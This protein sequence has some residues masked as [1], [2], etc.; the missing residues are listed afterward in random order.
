MVFG[1]AEFDSG[2]REPGAIVLV[3]VLGDAVAEPEPDMFA[4]G[5]AEFDNGWRVPGAGPACAGAVP[6]V[7]LEAAAGGRAELDSGLR[8]VVPEVAPG[9]GPLRPAVV[10][11]GPSGAVRVVVPVV[12][13]PVVEVPIEEVDVPVIIRPSSR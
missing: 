10:P 6:M 7:P 4:P 1:V 5:W 2:W 3:P 8:V 9:K 13:V 12:E 11:I